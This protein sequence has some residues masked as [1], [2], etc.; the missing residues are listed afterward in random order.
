MGAIVEW[1]ILFVCSLNYGQTKNTWNSF[2]LDQT[3]YGPIAVQERKKTAGGNCDIG[4][5]GR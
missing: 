1:K 5:N 3:K 2:F 4:I